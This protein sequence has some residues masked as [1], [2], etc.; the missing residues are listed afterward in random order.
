MKDRNLKYKEELLDGLFV[1]TFD[2]VINEQDVQMFFCVNK[3]GEIDVHFTPRESPT[4]H[5]YR[6]LIPGPW[7]PEGLVIDETKF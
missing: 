5:V 7:K 4:Q 3:K 1:I 2:W 6:K